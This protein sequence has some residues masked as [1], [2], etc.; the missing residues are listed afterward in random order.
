LGGSAVYARYVEPHW[1]EIVQ[2]DL[3]VSRLPGRWH[4][5]LLAHI[6]DV[7]VGHQVSGKYLI[8][9][10]RRLAGLKPDIV[11]VTG[12]FNVRPEITLFRLVAA[13]T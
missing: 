12:D 1:L 7:H 13:P 11:V 9:S 6:S 2:R 3:P 4:G 10:F 5:K 8:E